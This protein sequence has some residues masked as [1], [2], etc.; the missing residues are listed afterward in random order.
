MNGDNAELQELL[1]ELTTTKP[2]TLP[3]MERAVNFYECGPD[4]QYD[5]VAA[6]CIKRVLAELKGELK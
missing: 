6:Y 1:Q 4:G 3:C 2:I 5:H